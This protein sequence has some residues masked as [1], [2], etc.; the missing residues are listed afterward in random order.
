MIKPPRGHGPRWWD[1]DR[2][3]LAPPDPNA[4]C[5]SCGRLLGEEAYCLIRCQA[6]WRSTHEIGCLTQCDLEVRSWDCRDT[7]FCTDCRASHRVRVHEGRD[8]LNRDDQAQ[9]VLRGGPG[10]Q[11][12][13][14]LPMGP[15]PPPAPAIEEAPRTSE[16]LTRVG[17]CATCW[18]WGNDL[19]VC[20]DCQAPCHE[21]CLVLCPSFVSPRLLCHGCVPARWRPHLLTRPLEPNLGA[22]SSQ[23]SP[24]TATG[25]LRRCAG[26]VELNPGP[27]V[28]VPEEGRRWSS[29][30][31]ELTH[32]RTHARDNRPP[33]GEE[34]GAGQPPCGRV[35]HLC[36]L[37]CPVIILDTEGNEWHTCACG[38]MHCTG[39]P[40]W[41]LREEAAEAREHL[42]AKAA[43]QEAPAAV[44]AP[45]EGPR[46]IHA[47]P[48]VRASP[49]PMTPGE[50]LSLG[51]AD[52]RAAQR[53]GGPPPRPPSKAPP[54]HPPMPTVPQS[55]VPVQ[56]AAAAPALAS[57]QRGA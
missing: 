50:W 48:E 22:G 57:H 51:L 49:G 5:P 25:W 28:S 11:G 4:N 6:C 34:R 1:A 21:E 18:N 47:A 53:G 13:P 46:R 7:W 20:G 17:R 37:P 24:S 33:Q 43:P 38:S 45:E 10:D 23:G 8:G 44:A 40:G 14:P 31:V 15:V 41:A 36:R 27:R 3:R 19:E 42:E 52:L 30:A 39:M 26:G 12:D 29:A 16:V 54:A 55:S 9:D 32:A 56:G 35:C 2:A